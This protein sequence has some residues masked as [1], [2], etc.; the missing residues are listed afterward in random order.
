MR[1]WLLLEVSEELWVLVC[2]TEVDRII[3]GQRLGDHCGQWSEEKGSI[4]TM[5]RSLLS[6]RRTSGPQE[7]LF[8]IVIIMPLRLCVFTEELSIT[9]SMLIVH[10]YDI[11]GISNAQK[12]VAFTEDFR[13]SG[14]FTFY[15]NYNGS[16]AMWPH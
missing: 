2:A 4:V 8:Y 10:Y 16:E 13:S 5:L 6:S 11:R 14:R 1:S 15:W 7:R 3:S 12:P 9:Q